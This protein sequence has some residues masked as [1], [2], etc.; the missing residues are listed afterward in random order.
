MIARKRQIF[1]WYQEALAGVEGVTLNHEP[2]D[3]LNTYWMVTILLD[4]DL[5]LKKED[6]IAKMDAF[7][8]DCRPFFHPLSSQPP[9]VESEQARRAHEQN[10]SSYAISPYGVNLPSGLNLTRELVG[11][12]CQVFRGILKP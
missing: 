12:V 9:F 7:G 10:R 1:A 5:G 3:T 11:E 6:V 2:P 8:I 4:P